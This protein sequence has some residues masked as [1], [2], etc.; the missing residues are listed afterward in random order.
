MQIMLNQDEIEDAIRNHVLSQLAIREDQEISIDL[1]AG[2]GEN[3]FTATLDVR[4]RL[5]QTNKPKPAPAGNRTP[6]QIRETQPAHDAEP[7]DGPKQEE[8]PR[9]REAQKPA[10]PRTQKKGIFATVPKTAS[11]AAPKPTEETD[12]A[13]TQ[14]NQAE[15][16]VPDQETPAEEG[17]PQAARSAAEEGDQ[18]GAQDA[19]RDG[20]EAP[21]GQPESKKSI[22][23]FAPKTS[24]G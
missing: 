17:A 15:P 6:V 4:P 11:E 22:F 9:A 1:R 3:G 18:E 21:A 12:T 13:T 10:A 23:T 16:G 8:A 20:S 24:A 19:A 14:G 2:R 5:E 7:E